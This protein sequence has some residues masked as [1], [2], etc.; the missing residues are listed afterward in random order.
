MIISE[1]MIKEAI[2]DDYFHS[3][4]TIK[5]KEPARGN[6]YKVGLFR[7]GKGTLS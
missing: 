2:M 4:K 1:L 6:K 3:L 5:P 7:H